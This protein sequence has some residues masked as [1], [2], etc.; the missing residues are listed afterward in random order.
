[1]EPRRRGQ[2]SRPRE[3]ATGFGEPTFG[4]R[5]E[6]RLQKT[7]SRISCKCKCAVSDL[8]IEMAMRTLDE[9]K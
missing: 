2:E 9:M 6:R 4:G 5:L 3:E 7:F 1:M 8:S